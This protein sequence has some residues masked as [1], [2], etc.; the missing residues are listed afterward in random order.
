MNYPNF[1]VIFFGIAK[2]IE[3]C[4]DDE[5]AIEILKTLYVA[6]IELPL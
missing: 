4:E 6:A 1:Y 3:E 2:F 5:L